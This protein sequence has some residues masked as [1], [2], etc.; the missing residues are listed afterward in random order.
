MACGN[1]PPATVS[2]MNKLMDDLFAPWSGGKRPPLLT[3]TSEQHQGSALKAVCR[4]QW[5]NPP[6]PCA[7]GCHLETSSS[8]LILL[9]LWCGLR[10]FHLRGNLLPARVEVSA[11]GGPLSWWKS[12]GGTRG[13]Q[14]AVG[15]RCCS[16]LKQLLRDYSSEA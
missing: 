11:P 16:R 8:S 7:A 6:F 10:L 9:S 2:L 13:M 3:P 1:T 4:L 15:E 14:P 12:G 5:Q